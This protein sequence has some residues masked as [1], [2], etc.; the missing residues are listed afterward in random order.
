MRCAADTFWNHYHHLDVKR[1]AKIPHCCNHPPE[2]F[3]LRQLHGLGR[4]HPC[5]LQWIQDL[6]NP[7]GG[8]P[9]TG[10]SLFQRWLLAICCFGT[11]SEDLIGWYSVCKSGDVALSRLG[12]NPVVELSLLGK[13]VRWLS[14]LT[15]H[16]TWLNK[17][18]MCVYEYSVWVGTTVFHGM[19]N[20]D[21]SRG[22]CQFLWNL[23]VFTN[24]CGIQYW[25]VT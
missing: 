17:S 13:E 2:R 20:F 18:Q 23:Y 12:L 21:Q 24:F 10:M 6:V 25:P 15:V 3:I 19:R 5:V 9:T 11:Y 4:W 1:S 7:G 14:Y 22:I 8:W 16:H